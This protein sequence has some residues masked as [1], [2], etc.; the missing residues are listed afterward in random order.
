MAS[1]NAYQLDPDRPTAVSTETSTASGLTVTS[2]AYLHLQRC[3]AVVSQKTHQAQTPVRHKA[4]SPPGATNDARSQFGPVAPMRHKQPSLKQ[5]PP[6]ILAGQYKFKGPPP[7]SFKKRHHAT[8][9][10]TVNSFEPP[11]VKVKVES[12]CHIQ[13]Q[14]S[15]LGPIAPPPPKQNTLSF[16]APPPSM[17]M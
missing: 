4:L 16:K 10:T 5:H 14:A 3:V 15:L 11:P 2:K 6:K 17:L 13:H 7:V 1:S 8:T 12:F 9:T